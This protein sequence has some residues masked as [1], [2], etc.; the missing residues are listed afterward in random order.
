ML[1]SNG[2]SA[3]FF[4]A[5]RLT[6][7]TLTTIMTHNFDLFLILTSRENSVSGTGYEASH[8]ISHNGGA[9]C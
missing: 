9:F 7:F 8:L 3:A 5:P 2:Y 6:P 4:K 1:I